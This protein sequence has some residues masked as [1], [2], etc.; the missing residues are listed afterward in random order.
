MYKTTGAILIGA[1]LSA[2][3]LAQQSIVGT[4]KL[5]TAAAVIDGKPREEKG[6]APHGFLI[7]TPKYYAIFYTGPG[8]RKHGNSAAEK[9]ALWDTLTAFTATYKIEG[10]KITLTPQVSWNEVYNGSQQ[11][12]EIEMKGKRLIVSSGLRPYGRDP[13]KKVMTR[14]EWEKVE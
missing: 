5:V 4:Y 10:K 2:P 3:C 8:E 7:V 9:A 13:S 12:R 1:L 14:Q 11:V 6:G